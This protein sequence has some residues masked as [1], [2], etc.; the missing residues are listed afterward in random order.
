MGISAIKSQIETRAKAYHSKTPGLSKLPFPALAIIVGIALINVLV[1]IATG[2]VIHYHRDLAPTAI[3]AYSLGLRHALD[4]DHIAIIDLVTRRLVATGQ[5]P[6]AVGTFF[7]LG[8]STIVIITSVVVAATAEAISSKFG[9]FGRVGGIIGTSVSA[10]VLILLG[11][12]NSYILWRLVRQLRRYLSGPSEDPQLTLQGHGVMFGLLQKVFKLMDSIELEIA[13]LGIASIQ[14]AKGTSI[15]LILIFPILFTSGMCL[16]D[17]TDGAL[18]MALYTS[19]TA[20]K[21]RI[22]ILYYSIVLTVVTVVVAIVIGVIQLLSLV[23]N[24]AEPSGRFWDGVAVAGDHYDVIGGSI[25]GSFIVFGGLSVLFYRPWR[26]WFDEK[27]RIRQQQ[28]DHLDP[29]IEDPDPMIEL[30]DDPD[31]DNILADSPGEAHAHRQSLGDPR[32]E[33]DTTVFRRD[34]L[35]S[36]DDK[37]GT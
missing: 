31:R 9:T 19:T 2:V 24:I 28:R 7:S 6:V 17:T 33:I 13:L 37:K 4:A 15:W 18:M 5:K 34:T 20:A 11:I 25:C 27:R 14:G 26:R 21:D 1:W 8:H 30:G 36:N 23:S 32:R 22:A 35:D 3:I 16:L 10:G 12:A 29:A